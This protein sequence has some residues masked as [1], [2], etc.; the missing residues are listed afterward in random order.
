LFSKISTIFIP[1][2]YELQTDLFI[3]VFLIQIFSANRTLTGIS[4]DIEKNLNT[5]LYIF[6]TLALIFLIVIFNI[7][8]L[9]V[10]LSLNLIFYFTL[11]NAYSII[12]R[13]WKLLINYN[14]VH[15][16]L[17]FITLNYLDKF[18]EY[19]NLILFFTISLIVYLTP[20]IIS[21]YENLE[22]FSE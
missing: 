8:S 3:T 10:F 13:E 7:D 20:K 6:V 1:I 17:I 16:I 12:S 22:V 9:E 21:S 18:I 15:F 2:E 4:Y 19:Q 11:G 14:I 5:K